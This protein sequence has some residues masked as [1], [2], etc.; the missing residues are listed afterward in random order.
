LP[1]ATGGSRFKT[2]ASRDWGTALSVLVDKTLHVVE[3]TQH[4]SRE[5]GLAR[6][7]AIGQ[8]LSH[9][10]ALARDPD[11]PSEAQ[12]AVDEGEIR[13]RPVTLPG[14]RAG[15]RRVTPI[16][17]P[18]GWEAVLLVTF[19]GLHEVSEQ[20]AQ[21]A[22][23]LRAIIDSAVDAMIAIDEAG[24]IQLFNPAAEQTFGYW[25][26]EVLG[27]NV[28]ILM[29]EPYR[30][31]HDQYIQRYL[32]TG[33][34]RIIGIGRE[35][36]AQRKDGSLF[37]AEL[38]VSEIQMGGE[39]AFAGV[40]RDI[41]A[42]KQLQ[43]EAAD[44]VEREQQEIGQELHDNIGQQ[45]TVTRMLAERLCKRFDRGHWPTHE[46]LQELAHELRSAEQQVRSLSRTL[47]P[48]EVQRGGLVTAL[49]RLAEQ[50]EN[51]HKVNL[52]LNQVDI[53][54]E[55]DSGTATQ[56]LR[57]VQEAVRN[58]VTHGAASWIMVD[59]RG[60][61]NRFQLVVED[62]GKGLERD[63]AE[64]D[65]VGMRTMRYRANLFGGSLSVAPRDPHGVRLICQAERLPND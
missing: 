33:E 40:V 7:Q 4:V 9:I 64:V 5:L 38:S 32:K 6:E 31:Q 2:T 59:L 8:P 35:V 34:R 3:L 19:T 30:S 39:R 60:D 37:P 36:L 65:G 13:E 57:I 16:P 10:A 11:L 14:D 1:A 43:R 53:E 18:N 61:T 17:G 58:A 52:D 44:A 23:Y 41:T 24:R 20:Q 27:E 45:V 54:P 48:A 46:Q 29:P 12:L 22:A 51:A 28:A 21:E 42:H 25:R 26:T 15:I 47:I 49:K 55:L 63:V 50:W 56:L 62:N